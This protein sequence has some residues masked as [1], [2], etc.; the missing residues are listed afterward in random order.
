MTNADGSPTEATGA[1]ETPSA[2]S[3]PEA[4]TSA[5][6]PG[7]AWMPG[8]PIPIVFVHGIRTSASMWR[9]QVE[10][11][12]GIGHP[13]HA[14]DLPG[15]GSRIGEEFTVAA[16][17]AAID[18][19]VQALGGRVLLVGLSL[20]GYYSIAYAAQHPG[21]VIGL[22]AAGCSVVPRGAPIGAYRRL[23]AA[24]HRL[25]DRGLWLHTAFVRALLPASAQQDV[26]AGGVALDVMDAGL[27][28]TGTLHPLTDLAAYPGPVWLV[29][30]R[31]DQFRLQERRFRAASRDGTLV[32]IPGA[33]HLSSLAQP[34][35][36]TAVVATVAARLSERRSM[37]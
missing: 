11:L 15:H 25:P 17:L 22:I 13:V 9:R 29:N 7:P 3:T 8:C 5:G 12:R 16:A 28:A 36:F 33:T 32:V 19:G 6:A 31:F 24:I 10:A 1:T 34:G 23:A 35:R 20:G 18:A 26:L 37:G 30:G 27:R 4:S 21:A 2:A 14:I